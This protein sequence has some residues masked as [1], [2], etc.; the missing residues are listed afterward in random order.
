MKDCMDR[1]LVTAP[2]SGTMADVLDAMIYS[3][4]PSVVVQ[5]GDEIIGIASAADVGRMVADGKD[6]RDTEVKSFLSACQLTGSSPCVQIPEN[7]SVINA[8][9]VMENYGISELIVVNEENKLVG[10]ISA[11]DALKGWRKGV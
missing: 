9:K 11:L 10:T 5:D 2:R 4:H 3:N 8:L 7:E 1:Q 6:L